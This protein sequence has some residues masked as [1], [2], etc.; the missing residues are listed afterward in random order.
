MRIKLTIVASVALAVCGVTLAGC[1]KAEQKP[2]ADPYSSDVVVRKIAEQGALLN[3]AVKQKDFAAIDNQA[4]YLQGMV[5]ALYSKLDAEQKQRSG[6]FLDEVIK[7]AEELDHAA[8]RRHEGATVASM[9]KLQGLLK[10]L[11]K[12]FPGTKQGS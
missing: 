3:D 10:E 9:E 7:V 11:E 2:P 1:K 12:Q 6:S 4:Y 5:K 8:G